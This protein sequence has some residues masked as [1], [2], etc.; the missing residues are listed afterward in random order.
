MSR[1]AARI[2]ARHAG[3][4]ATVSGKCMKV[5]ALNAAASLAFLSFPEMTDRFTAAT[6]SRAAAAIS[7]E[8]ALDTVREQ[9]KKPQDDKRSRRHWEARWPIQGITKP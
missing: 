7:C 2:V 6:A 8:A 4:N 9:F 1:A 5:S 3:A